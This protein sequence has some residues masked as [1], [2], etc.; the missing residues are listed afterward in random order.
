MENSQVAFTFNEA[1]D[2]LRCS[3]TFLYRLINQDKIKSFKIG[4][5]HLIYAEELK[6]FIAEA[7][8]KGEV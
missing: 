6:R 4:G 8:R 2:Q 5:K 1:C 3:R 7:S